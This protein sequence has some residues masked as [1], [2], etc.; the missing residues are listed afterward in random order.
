MSDSRG[1]DKLDNFLG[2]VERDG[3]L[4]WLKKYK[5]KPNKPETNDWAI[6]IILDDADPINPVFVEIETDEGR[7]IRVGTRIVR[8]DG[9]T[10]LRITAPEIIEAN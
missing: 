10:R 6:N 4:D 8:D 3:F 7:S 2:A 1:K 5:R 9:L